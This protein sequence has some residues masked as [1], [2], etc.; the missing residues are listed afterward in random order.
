MRSRPLQGPRSRPGFW[1]RSRRLVGVAVVVGTALGVALPLVLDV[2]EE[3]AADRQRLSEE[4][5][6]DD[7]IDHIVLV[8]MENHAYDD[9]FGVYC[10]SA[11]PDCP[12]P[13]NGIPPGTCVPLHPGESDSP[14]VKPYNFTEANWT[15]GG[16]MPHS[17]GSSLAAWNHGAMNDFYQAE[18]SG[19]NPFGH[20]NGTTAPIYWDLAEEYGLDDDF[21]SSV[22][23]YSLPN[24]WHLVAGQ[25]PSQI[26]NNGTYVGPNLTQAG[27]A[28]IAGDHL[29]L[30]QANATESIED[31]LL[32]DPSVSWTYYDYPLGT[33]DRA[34]ALNATSNPGVTGSAFNYWNPQAA[35]A[36][37]YNASF[38]SHFVS[39]TAFY[40]DARNGTLPNFSWVIPAGQDSDHPPWNSTTAQGWVASLVDAVESSPEWDSTVMFV[41]WDEYGG[42]YDHV[43]PP[44]VDGGQ[45]LGFRVPLLVIGPYVREDDLFSGFGYFESILH[46]M[47]VRYHLGCFTALDCDAPLP[48]QE[49]NFDAPPRAPMLFPTNVTNASYPMALQPAAAAT[50]TLPAYSP[51]TMY[52]VFPHGEAPDLD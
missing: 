6:F 48:F 41:T 28:T 22:L 10:P 16:P 43:D 40:G 23:D 3:S 18:M 31:L 12:T 5:V 38:T 14:C 33:Y 52:V 36:E 11:G 35:K 32:R 34:I 8:V 45:Q 39:N 27:G 47:E 42:F 30:D 17:L 4:A 44:T 20:Y 15:V 7:H 13:N 9:Y 25:A 2:V 21:F 19:L 26:L 51:P 50:A 29:Y 24:H 46:L 37:S 1:T 49:F